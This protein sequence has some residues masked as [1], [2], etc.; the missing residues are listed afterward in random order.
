MK[1]IIFIIIASLLIIP[2]MFNGGN[3]IGIHPFIGKYFWAIG[4]PIGFII[5]ISAMLS[6]KFRD[7]LFSQI[8]MWS[9]KLFFIILM[10][11]LIPAAFPAY[12]SLAAGAVVNITSTEKYESVATV[13]RLTDYRNKLSTIYSRKICE[14]KVKIKDNNDNEGY[15]CLGR[16]LFGFDAGGISLKGKAFFINEGSK[17]YLIGRRSWLGIVV[18][19]FTI[20]N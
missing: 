16:K 11:T 20:A 13:L 4:Y 1:K 19:D 8:N 2:F 17:M 7:H 14:F 10:F 6:S 5:P 3:V 12:I 15:L 9:L 18:D